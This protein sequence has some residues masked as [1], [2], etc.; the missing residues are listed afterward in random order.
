MI[1]G[2]FY[3]QKI[4]I[5]EVSMSVIAV[6]NPSWTS[7]EEEVSKIIAVQQFP[8]KQFCLHAKVQV[9]ECLFQPLT[10][11]NFVG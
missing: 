5:A 3:V 9:S 6:G 8:K 4:T 2:F 10:L 7:N 1:Q 11:I